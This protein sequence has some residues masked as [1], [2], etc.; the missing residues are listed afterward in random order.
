V[1]EV[2]VPG[3][4]DHKSFQF[5]SRRHYPRWHQL[6]MTAEM[7]YGFRGD[8]CSSDSWPIWP[9][10]PSS[11]P[12]GDV[13]LGGISWSWLQRCFMGTRSS[14]RLNRCAHAEVRALLQ[15]HA[16]GTKNNG[17]HRHRK[18]CL[19]FNGEPHGFVALFLFSAQKLLRPGYFP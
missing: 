14:V 2:L 7:F 6:V 5:T 4:P 15:F 9:P 3:Q 19:G 13:T 17:R 18:S 8:G 12:P 10:Y 16:G 1:V 11:S